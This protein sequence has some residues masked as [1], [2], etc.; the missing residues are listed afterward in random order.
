MSEKC[1]TQGRHLNSN[2]QIVCGE[3]GGYNDGR[4][5]YQIPKKHETHKGLQQKR[6]NNAQQRHEEHH[7]ALKGAESTPQ[8]QLG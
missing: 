6:L 5:A 4:K 3:E 7:K 2:G 8:W 1:E